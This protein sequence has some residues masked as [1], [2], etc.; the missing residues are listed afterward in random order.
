MIA[1][2]KMYNGSKHLICRLFS[3]KPAAKA[4]DAK[5]LFQFKPKVVHT[6]D[7]K[8]GIDNFV[9]RRREYKKEMSLLRSKLQKD[10]KDENEKLELIRKAERKRILQVKA[11]NL[12]QKRSDALKRQEED[13]K[14]KEIANI[15]Y[16]EKLARGNIVRNSE[17]AG[18]IARYNQLIEDLLQEKPFWITKQTIESKIVP[19]LFEKP[20]STGL[21]SKYSE[22]WRW[23][24]SSL[25][26]KRIF[27]INNDSENGNELLK[28]LEQRAQLKAST[29]M[30]LEDFFNSMVSTGSEREKYKETISELSK[31]INEENLDPFELQD[32]VGRPG[33]ISVAND[34]EKWESTIGMANTNEN[35]SNENSTV[36]NQGKSKKEKKQLPLSY[37]NRKAAKK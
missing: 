25:D 7:V 4:A 2:G 9:D 27:S 19:A 15:A 14:R 8:K 5:K 16:K 37:V 33:V 13:R 3:S 26:L 23:H 21:S 12:R 22:Y 32:D 24:V 10:I 36:R 11:I 20:T 18:K 35:V 30:E 6:E 28:R 34:Y 17:R 29:T 31:L 1:A